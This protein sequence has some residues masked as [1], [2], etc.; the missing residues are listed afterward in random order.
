MFFCISDQPKFINL[1]LIFLL[2]FFSSFTHAEK[3]LEKVSVQLDWKY[4]FE[5]AGFIAAK[6]KGFYKEAG[7]DVDLIEYQNSI[8]IGADVLAR[9]STYG[10]KKTSLYIKAGKIVPIKLLATYFPKPPLILITSPDIKSPNDLIGKKVM[11]AKEHL[12]QSALGL[13]L[14]HFYLTDKNIHPIKHS[15]DINDFIQHKVDAFSAYRTNEI[16][17][18]EQQNIKYNIVD[19]SLYGYNLPVGNLFTSINEAE[20][21]PDRTRKFVDA[22][23]KGWVYALSHETELISIIY[24]KYSK[25]KSIEALRFEAE[26]IKKLMPSSPT[27]IYSTPV[28]SDNKK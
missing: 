17:V 26:Q 20:E 12:H 27:D 4:Q 25:K 14:D 18:L 16:F 23:N 10:I 11:L 5:F 15:F 6:E 28:N 9:K 13:M 1:F 7:L 2:T 3:P 19:P 24:N 21:N 8:D 22:S